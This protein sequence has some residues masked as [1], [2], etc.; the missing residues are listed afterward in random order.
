[1]HTDD[2]LDD[3]TPAE[4]FNETV[5]YGGAWIRDDGKFHHVLNYGGHY[6][7]ACD[8]GLDGDMEA[9]EQGWIRVSIHR[10]YSVTVTLPPNAKDAALPA[11]RALRSILPDLETI[12]EVFYMEEEGGSPDDMIQ[13]YGEAKKFLNR[14]ISYKVR[15]ELRAQRASEEVEAAA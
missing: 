7:L 1:M 2:T 11:L 12:E 14:V 4:E 5:G 13:S 3:L 6:D 8:L 9:Y 15:Q 10:G